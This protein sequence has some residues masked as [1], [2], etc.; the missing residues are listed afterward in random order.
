[1]QRSKIQDESLYYEAKK[2]DGTLPLIGVN[3]FL[4]EKPE[5][6]AKTTIE[7]IRSTEAEKQAQV[8]SVERF[9]HD[10][11]AVSPAAGADPAKIG[12]ALV[13]LQ[14]RAVAHQNVFQG[15]M[16][17]VK[18]HSLGQISHALYAVGGEYRRSM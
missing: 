16:E 11:N 8:T 12:G 1:Y 17:A 15:L 4:P 3:T 6:E 10:R 14:R 7:L 5:H 9:R 18:Y 13:D 2:H